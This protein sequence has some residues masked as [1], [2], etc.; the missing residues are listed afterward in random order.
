MLAGGVRGTDAASAFMAATTGES[1]PGAAPPDEPPG[2]SLEPE[3]LLGE[4]PEPPEPPL[5]PELVPELA[6][7]LV[8]LGAVVVVV[9]GGGPVLGVVGAGV[10]GAGVVGTVAGEVARARVGAPP[11][12]R[13][14]ANATITAAVPL[15]GVLFPLIPKSVRH[16]PVPR[17]IRDSC[18][19]GLT[20]RTYKVHGW[21]SVVTQAISVPYARGR[22]IHDAD[23][24]ILEPP[25]WLASNADAGLRD[26]ITPLY[27][28]RTPDGRDLI[29]LFEARHADPAYRAADA[30]EI[31]LRKNWAA[32]G[33]FIS[34]DRPGALD[35][36]GFRSQLV[37]NTFSN[38]VL[39][40]AEHSGDMEY[41][42]GVARAH[43]RGIVE[44]CAVDSRLLAVGY[45]PLADLDRA[46]PFAIEAIDMGCRALMVAS[47]CPPGHAPSHIGL[48]GFWRLA[49]ESRTPVVLHVGGG[50]RL[51][52]PAFFENGHPPVPD[53]HG[54]DGNF[55]SVDYMA[56][57]YPVMQ[58]LAV[59][60]IDGVLDR[61]PDLRVGVI[62]QGA[63]WLPGFIR[64]LDSAA[65]AFGKNEERLQ[66]L[67]LRPSELVR[68]Q[69]RVTPYPH[70]DAGWIISQSGP[71]TCMFSSDYPH[72]EGG[73][74]PLARF[75]R[76]LEGVDEAAADGFYRA[77]FV[78]L[79]GGSIA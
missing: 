13:A 33:S 61:H 78:D 71:E 4:P 49:E 67:T 14:A 42:Y 9:V 57:P 6:P 70:E 35:L 32:T 11:Q 40:E 66:K 29:E 39:Q 16:S 60:V 22:A 36:L 24:H 25:D 34:S 38:R 64:S 77:N 54:G 8:P 51:I 73:R 53:F 50:G 62:E 31:M 23:A 43:N 18:P 45:I 20:S 7:E 21:G 69:V 79:M 12:L 65:D 26:R 46:G 27:P 44:F 75:A 55:R 2:P 37:F 48:E 15:V 74:N 59:L 3:E 52:D 1:G 63:S 17:R 10:L 41:A 47:A 56:I 68:R 72:V 5:G 28:S 30:D 19:S 58:A 76:S